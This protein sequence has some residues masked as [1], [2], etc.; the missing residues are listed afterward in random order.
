MCTLI[1]IFRFAELA[2]PLPTS[3]STKVIKRKKGKTMKTLLI[4]L[5]I[6]LLIVSGIMQAGLLQKVVEA[7]VKAVEATA[8]VVK[9]VFTAPTEVVKD[10]VTAPAKVIGETPKPVLQK[11]EVVTVKEEVTQPKEEIAKPVI[12]PEA[13]KP[14]EIKT[15]AITLEEDE[16][17]DVDAMAEQAKELAY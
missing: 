1:D 13:A 10:V 12:K 9:D 14:T 3:E 7:P 16:E 15:E 11:E 17:V 5:T 2:P 4:S 8:T 6:A